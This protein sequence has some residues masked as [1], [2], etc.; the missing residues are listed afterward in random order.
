MSSPGHHKLPVL[1]WYS[2]GYEKT[3]FDDEQ[4]FE[5]RVHCI[6]HQ[7]INLTDNFRDIVGQQILYM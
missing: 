6:M 4:S 5:I 2:Y 3:W 7:T 1:Y